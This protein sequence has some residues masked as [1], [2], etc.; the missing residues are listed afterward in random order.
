MKP[1]RLKRGRLELLGTQYATVRHKR[2]ASAPEVLRATAYLPGKRPQPSPLF[3]AP[4]MFL[5][6]MGL[7]MNERRAEERLEVCLDARWDGSTANY[8]CRLVDLSEGGCYIDTLGEAVVGE[9]ISLKVLISDQQ[10]LQLSG[11]VAHYKPSLGFG[12][13]FINVTE[14]QRSRIRLLLGK[15]EAN[16][17]ESLGIAGAMAEIDFLHRDAM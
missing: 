14:E 17:E 6:R 7:L 5:T 1:L 13:R 3:P 12:V 8:S 4:K 9:K 11:E 10:W 2:R 16:Q 15:E